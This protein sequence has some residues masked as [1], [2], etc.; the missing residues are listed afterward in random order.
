LTP[1]QRRRFRLA[2]ARF[3]EDLRRG[4]F[5]AGLRVKDFRGRT[6]WF[7]MTWAPDGRA[8]FSYGEELMP[9]EPHVIWERIGGHEIF[10]NP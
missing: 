1:D 6:G 8:L 3:I 9:G 2:V 5:R 10:G 4:S 7:E